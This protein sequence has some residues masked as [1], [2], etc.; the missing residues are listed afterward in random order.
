MSST[1]QHHH[2]VI[3]DPVGDTTYQHVDVTGTQLQVGENG[4]EKHRGL[5]TEKVEP[6]SFSSEG[7]SLGFIFLNVIN[8]A[9]LLERSGGNFSQN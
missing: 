6:V 8:S 7:Y 9:L 2:N 1:C 3:E 4:Q 5:A